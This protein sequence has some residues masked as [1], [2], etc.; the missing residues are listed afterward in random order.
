MNTP[1]TEFYRLDP[2]TGCN[3]FLSFVETLDKMSS[4]EGR[5]SFSILYLDMN[6]MTMLN[7]TKGHSYGDS[8]LHWL[9]IVLQ[10]E[11]RSTTY[12]MG[13]DD[14][15]VILTDG[16]HAE[17]ESLLQQ[18]FARLN[19]EGEQLGIPTPPAAIALIHFDASY[20]F[21]IN[22]IMFHLGETVRDIKLNKERTIRIFQAQEL[23]K[24]K[25]KADEQSP[26]SILYSWDA[27]CSIANEAI[28]RILAIERMLDATQKTA[29]LDSISG[30]PNLRA[31]LQKMEKTIND[32]AVSK[33]PF[34]ILLTDGDN[35][36]KYNSIS[37]AAGDTAIQNIGAVLSKN[38]R[39]GDFVARWRTGDEFIIILPNTFGEGAKIVAERFCSAIREAS[40]AWVLP[41]SIS[42]G[43]ATFPKHGSNTNELVDWAESALK[44]AKDEGKDRVI[45][46][47]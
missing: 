1:S 27:L 18:L 12:R 31:A 7:K 43:I 16:V 28:G 34:S 3:N 24:S 30:L 41:S 10:E 39:P 23:I 19:K 2:L 47:E 42:I 32:A 40:K 9:G 4:E 37:Y 46:L 14:F 6:F 13:W 15:S 22:D 11:S 29:Y 17:H 36:R 35:L 5:G 45:L 38:L 21:S 8:V 44:R 33:Q 25:A 20:I 26:D